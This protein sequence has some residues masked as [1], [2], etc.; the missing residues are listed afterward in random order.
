M[1]SREYNIKHFFHDLTFMNFSTNEA[2]SGINVRIT[3]C[4]MS[5][6]RLGAEIASGEA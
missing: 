5:R 2:L 3:N 1:N 6:S 4:E